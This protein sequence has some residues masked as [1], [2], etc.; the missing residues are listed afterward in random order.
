MRPRGSGER[1]EMERSKACG[2]GLRRG[3]GGGLALE[4]RWRKSSIME[5]KE[6]GIE[7]RAYGKVS[8]D[9][10]QMKEKKCCLKLSS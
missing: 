9:V 3:K 4:V 2:E 1:V 6:F 10:V 7:V 5:G 8:I